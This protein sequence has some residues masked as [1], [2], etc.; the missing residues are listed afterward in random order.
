VYIDLD[1]VRA[2][3]GQHPRESEHRGYREIHKPPSRYPVR[4]LPLL[5]SI[6]SSGFSKFDLQG[7]MHEPSKNLL[8]F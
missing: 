7:L 1:K 4:L 3:S 8:I 2:G 5:V 6:E